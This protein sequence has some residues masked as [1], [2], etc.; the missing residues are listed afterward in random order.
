M[1]QEYIG[2]RG[3]MPG[4]WSFLMTDLA[5][6]TPEELDRLACEAVGIEPGFSVTRARWDSW[7]SVSTESAA[8]AMLKAAAIKL[9]ARLE[10]VGNAEGWTCDLWAPATDPGA[11]H[12]PAPGCEITAKTE[13]GAVALA[14]ATWAQTKGK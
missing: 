13:E 10:I 11:G 5:D 14:V 3:A 2:P 4:K 7:P 6:L 8:C 12:W 1:R 9:G